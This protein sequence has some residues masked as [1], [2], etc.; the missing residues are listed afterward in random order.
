MPSTLN[1][2]ILYLMPS[3][4]N[5]GN[6]MLRKI[7]KMPAFLKLHSISQN[8]HCTIPATVNPTWHGFL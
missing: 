2:G 5:F 1:F 6:N 8:F 4:L 3:T 7:F